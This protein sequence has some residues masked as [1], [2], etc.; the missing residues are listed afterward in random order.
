MKPSASADQEKTLRLRGQSKEWKEFQRPV[1]SIW[2]GWDAFWTTDWGA[3][4]NGECKGQLITQGCQLWYHCR[5]RGAE[6]ANGS[7]GR[8]DE[9]WRQLGQALELLLRTTL[10][11]QRLWLA[12]ILEVKA[13]RLHLWWDC[14]AP[15]LPD[16][17]VKTCQLCKKDPE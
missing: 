3:A 6:G 8:Q 4:G 1:A 9:G 11:Q 16:L 15:L 5:W 7:L 10:F 13:A 2:M 17:W 14:Q 12:S